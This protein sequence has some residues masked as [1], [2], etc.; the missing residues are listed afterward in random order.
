MCVSCGRARLP[1]II[2][3]GGETDEKKNKVLRHKVCIRNGAFIGWGRATH[4][5]GG[6]WSV[7]S[8]LPASLP[9]AQVFSREAGDDTRDRD[10]ERFT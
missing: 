4:P 2:M 5:L 3:G 9:R 1:G 10:G 7:M 8:G 6:G